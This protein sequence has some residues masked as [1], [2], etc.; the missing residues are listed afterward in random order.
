MTNSQEFEIYMASQDNDEK[1]VDDN[2]D[3][4]S[5]AIGSD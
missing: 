2:N 3:L 1:V 5:L 4:M